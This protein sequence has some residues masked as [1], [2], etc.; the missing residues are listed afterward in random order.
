[1]YSAAFGKTK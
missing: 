1:M